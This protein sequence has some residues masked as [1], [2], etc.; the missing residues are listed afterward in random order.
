MQRRILGWLQDEQGATSAEYA[1]LA[2][3][4]AGV[5]VLSVTQFGQAVIKLF[6]KTNTSLPSAS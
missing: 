6:E 5:I 3:L 4:I 2:A 1:I